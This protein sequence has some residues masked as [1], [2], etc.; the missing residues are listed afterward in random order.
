MPSLFNMI[1]RSFAA[2]LFLSS[3]SS[4]LGQESADGPTS[5]PPAWSLNCASPDAASGELV[6]QIEQRFF[7]QQ[8]REL[9]MV[10]A[11]TKKSKDA[12]LSMDLVLP[13]GLDLLSGVSY[14]I[15]AGEIRT[16]AIGSSR[17]N[18]AITSIPLSPD[19]LAA[20]KVGRTLMLKM[21]TSAGR[22][23]SIPSSLVGLTAAIDRMT[24]IK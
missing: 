18:G 6:C 3:A 2:L 11:I 15:D 4:S 10:L 16:A 23:F 8:T 14:Q 20:L 5:S 9:V 7:R 1:V 13:H 24:A 17:Q 19:L 21:K 22:E 12:T